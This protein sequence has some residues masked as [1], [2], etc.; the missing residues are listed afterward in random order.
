MYA[1]DNQNVPNIE[2]EIQRQQQ[3]S[4]H[5]CATSCNDNE[6]AC[7]GPS[8][9]PTVAKN[10]SLPL[11]GACASVSSYDDDN[12]S[13]RYTTLKDIQV[14]LDEIDRSGTRYSFN[15]NMQDLTSFS[16]KSTIVAVTITN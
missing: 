2:Q 16:E 5:H 11:N 6:V 4:N 10:V 14:K 12:D 15:Y 1:T 9:D 7:S 3:Q 13:G 8:N